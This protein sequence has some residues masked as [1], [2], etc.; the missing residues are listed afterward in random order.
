M[1]GGSIMSVGVILQLDGTI[2]NASVPTIAPRH[3]LKMTE[4]VDCGIKGK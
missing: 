2:K 3:H 4:I 1:T